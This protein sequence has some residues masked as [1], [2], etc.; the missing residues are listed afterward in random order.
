MMTII[1]HIR[2]KNLARDADSFSL[3]SAI[4]V[5]DEPTVQNTGH[6]VSD[7]VDFEICIILR[8]AIDW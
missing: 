3:P 5:E 6:P 8:S 2:R 1:G 7:L 4:E